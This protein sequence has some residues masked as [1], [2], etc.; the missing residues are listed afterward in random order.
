MAWRG[1]ACRRR[2]R[3]ASC[4]LPPQNA[5]LANEHLLV[6]VHRF[7]MELQLTEANHVA[8]RHRHLN[9]LASL[10]QPAWPYRNHGAAVFPL[11]AAV[12]G[13]PC[14]RLGRQDQA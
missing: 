9:A 12:L 14:V 7:R 6:A 5:L 4:L 3:S 1:P 11:D 10:S 8:D 2:C 13:P